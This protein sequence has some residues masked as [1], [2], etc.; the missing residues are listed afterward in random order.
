MRT[1]SF[2]VPLSSIACVWARGVSMGGGRGERLDSPW[3]MISTLSIVRDE[4]VITVTEA[5]N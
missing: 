4:L 2:D 3:I 1:Q 5:F